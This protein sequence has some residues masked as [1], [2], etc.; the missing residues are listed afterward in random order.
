MT[1]T[2][3]PMAEVAELLDLLQLQQ[4]RESGS[5]MTKAELL[6]VF[7]R[8]SQQQRSSQDAFCS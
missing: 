5:S 4:Q 7:Q 3:T 1:M 8:K 2:I 6:R